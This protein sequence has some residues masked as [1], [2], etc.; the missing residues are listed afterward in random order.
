M[1]KINLLFAIVFFG[2]LLVLESCELITNTPAPVGTTVTTIDTLSF[3]GQKLNNDDI[4]DLTNNDTYN[5]LRKNLT[6]GKDIYGFKLTTV[7]DNSS[8][9]TWTKQATVNG[10][11]YSAYFGDA[12][13]YCISTFDADATASKIFRTADGGKSF[14]QVFPNVFLGQ[15]PIKDGYLN[16]MTFAKDNL[17]GWAV[18]SNGTILHTDNGGAVWAVQKSG[19]EQHFF[20][21]HFID[22]KNGWAVGDSGT[23]LH[24][25]NGG[26]SWVVQKSGTVDA[27]F[28]VQFINEKNGWI[29]GGGILHT[30][31]GGESWESQNVSGVWNGIHFI[32]TNN[33]WIFGY[34]GIAH[35]TDGGGSW[36]N[37]GLN[38]SW[39][40][41]CQ[42]IDEN[43]GWVLGY[44]NPDYF[45]SRTK[46]GGKSWS[47]TKLY[48]LGESFGGIKMWDENT[49]VA[50]IG[51]QVFRYSKSS[52]FTFN[53]KIKD[54]NNPD[55]VLLKRTFE[56]VSISDWYKIPKL[57]VLDST[58][59]ANVSEYFLN[60]TKFGYDI[61]L[62]DDKITPFSFKLKMETYFGVHVKP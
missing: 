43:N 19:T 44:S 39:I 62:V 61:S 2:S 17:N 37:Q 60:N 51:S 11:I 52:R 31:N 47:K 46:D 54:V 35:T 58:E 14:V 9:E 1:K 29:S 16:D 27:L 49:G 34:K 48:H 21:V 42:F 25:N 33:G 23:I 53:F 3:N 40:Y 15:E 6:A 30:N 41:V 20:G 28:D 32:D 55:N 4:V 18:G 5:D 45:V 8:G 13:T 57:I 22:A 56:D 59:R 26:I 7:E 36:T 38:D 10:N 50:Y 12:L 24:T